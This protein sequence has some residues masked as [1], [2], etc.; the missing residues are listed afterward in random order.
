MGLDG[1]RR[2]ES[3]LFNQMQHWNKRRMSLFE[4]V[5]PPSLQIHPFFLSFF[6]QVFSLQELRGARSPTCTHLPMAAFQP[7]RLG[8]IWGICSECLSCRDVSEKRID[9]SK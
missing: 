5:S 7:G 4:A 2:G 1:R 6:S 9:T 8:G 3:H